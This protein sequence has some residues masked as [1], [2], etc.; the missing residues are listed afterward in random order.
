M[1]YFVLHICFI[2]AMFAT[3]SL[4][5]AQSTCPP[6]GNCSSQ[7]MGDTTSQANNNQNHADQVGST[8][9][10]TVAGVGI[11]GRNDLQQSNNA[12][13]NSLNAA[14]GGGGSAN[15]IGNTS[16]N[17]NRS[18]VGNTSSNS[19]GNTLSNGNNGNGNGSNNTTTAS[20]GAGGSA[21]QAASS[22]SKSG[23]QNGQNIGTGNTSV[24]A[25]TTSS[26]KAIYIPP[27]VPPTPASQLAVGN[28]VKETLA[29]GPIVRKRSMPV[30]GTYF[31]LFLNSQIEQ[32]H[33]DLIEP[34]L[35]Q[36]GNETYRDVPISDERGT[37]FH[38]YGSQVVMFTAIVG[39]AGARNIAIGGGGSEGAWGQG[40]GGSSGSIQQMVTTVQIV[41][42]DMGTYITP[43][44]APLVRVHG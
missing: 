39:L 26:Y 12:A 41:P 10:N 3:P 9:N 22:G 42:C 6:T 17:D 18:S 24:Q 44:I 23:A 21:S 36:N 2:A 1:K 15:S 32:G 35:D 43:V 13:N 8:A 37:G 34:L 30:K 28:I 4:S 19:G 7:N 38:R 5:A 20:G 16:N 11:T 25:N 40:G 33:D 31:G 27:V 14:G 29:C